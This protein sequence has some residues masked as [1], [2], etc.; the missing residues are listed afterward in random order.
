LNHEIFSISAVLALVAA[1]QG[2][3]SFQTLSSIAPWELSSTR[4]PVYIPS[5]FTAEQYKKF[6]TGE[7]AKKK[8]AAKNNL[9]Q[10]GPKG[11]L[12]AFEKNNRICSLN[13]KITTRCS[14]WLYYYF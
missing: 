14:S 11:M 2:V 8:A 5:D 9:G 7:E 10:M 12:L 13:F 6:K 4:L 3:D 1:Q